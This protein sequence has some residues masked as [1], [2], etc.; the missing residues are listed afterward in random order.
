[1]FHITTILI[2]ASLLAWR[3]FSL[4]R[5]P[6]PPDRPLRAAIK[7]EA[8]AWAISFLVL[9]AGFALLYWAAGYF[10]PIRPIHEW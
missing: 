9:A 1:M 8:V 6:N 5:Q 3:W 2:A 4:R 7:K 10:G